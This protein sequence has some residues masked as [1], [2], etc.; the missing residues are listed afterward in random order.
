MLTALVSLWSHRN[1]VGDGG[2]Q[3]TGLDR[4]GRVVD[5]RWLVTTSGTALDRFQYGYDQDGNVLY[6]NN[7]VNSAFSEL[8]HA[9]GSS[10][11][12]D[13]LNQLVAFSRGTLNGTNDTISS[14][15]ASE[16]WTTDAAGNFTSAAGTSETNNLQNEAT[17]FGSATLTY[18][19]NG[20]LTTDQA[21]NTLVYDAWNR[22]VAYKTGGTTLETL[23]YDGLD[24]LIVQNPGTATDL[25]YSDQWQVLEERQGSTV[26]AH[27]V[28]SPLYVDGLVLRDRSTGGGTLNER[29]WV[30]Q[31]ANWNVTALVNGSGS[32]V[33]RYVY[34]PYGVTTVLNA[35]WGTL[36]GSAYAWIYGHQ[37]GR[38]DGTT[39]LYYFEERWESAALQRWTTVDP[40]GF[41]GGDVDL[42]RSEGNR[43]TDGV[44]PS[45]LYSWGEFWDDATSIGL[46]VLDNGASLGAHFSNGVMGL[47]DVY[48]AIRY[49]QWGRLIPWSIWYYDYQGMQ[50]SWAAYQSNPLLTDEERF[51]YFFMTNVPYSRL[52]MELAQMYVGTSVYAH[53]WGHPLTPAGYTQRGI[54]VGM[55]VGSAYAGARGPGF[56]G[57][58]PT[59]RPGTAPVV[60]APSTQVR[61]P[62]P[63]EANFRPNPSGTDAPST[64]SPQ[65]SAD[66]GFRPAG[67]SQGSTGGGTPIAPPGSTWTPGPVPRP[68]GGAPVYFMPP[69]WWA[70]EFPGVSFPEHWQPGPTG[71]AGNA[72]QPPQ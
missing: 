23:S 58:A 37:G 52:P 32:V 57:P 21:G 7:L 3:Y 15:S 61:P 65:N 25:Y 11:G 20:N 6:K 40:S 45:G 8:Y 70:E 71:R 28:W 33:E 9:N 53:D 48:G 67:G 27:Y 62:A 44:D 4:F 36:S 10:N 13:N 18:D 30:Q 12:Y 47:P 19:A 5:Q 29:L 1:P 68:G 50:A 35:S 69:E 2:D 64:G 22:L 24:R 55:D 41:G 26:T 43:P 51:G 72:W 39:G 60:E 66:P 49:R 34:D 56:R 54:N 38:W 14:P 59:A 16:T 46:V 31:D 17:G 42:Y 63:N